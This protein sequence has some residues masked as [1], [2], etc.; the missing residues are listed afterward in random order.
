VSDAQDMDGRTLIIDAIDHSVFT[1]T[2]LLR[3]RE[4]PFKWLDTSTGPRITFEIVE[5]SIQSLLQRGVRALEE[6]LCT[7]A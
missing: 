1:H 3:A 4:L 7:P 2:I 6:P 5:T